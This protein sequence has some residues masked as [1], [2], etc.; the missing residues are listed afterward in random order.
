MS[1]T[2]L[3]CGH[4]SVVDAGHPLA[5]GTLLP[6]Q[7]VL[8]VWGSGA[9]ARILRMVVG[10][11]ALTPSVRFVL[12]FFPKLEATVLVFG[13]MML[14]GLPT[15]V[16]RSMSGLFLALVAAVWSLV[17]RWPLPRFLLDQVARAAPG[18]D[19]DEGGE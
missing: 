1:A 6:V 15:A 3:L 7:W 12:L 17:E 13:V 18:R 4:E 14:P 10:R 19:D 16:I 9:L 11:S 2:L 5:L 8:A